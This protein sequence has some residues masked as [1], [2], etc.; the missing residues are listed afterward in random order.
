M[1]RLRKYLKTAFWGSVLKLLVIAVLETKKYRSMLA[2]KNFSLVPSFSG[3][4]AQIKIT[5]GLYQ[6]YVGLNIL[7]TL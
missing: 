3:E 2:N 5:F 4:E 7:L 1:A 6:F